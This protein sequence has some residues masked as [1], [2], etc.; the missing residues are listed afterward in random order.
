LAAE[1]LAGGEADH[2]LL[3]GNGP[4]AEGTAAPAVDPPGRPTA[5]QAVGRRGGIGEGHDEE[6]RGDGGI[7]Q[8]GFRREQ[9]QIRG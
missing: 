4:I 2:H 7:G 6:V 5:S 9:E 3:P 1:E 8:R